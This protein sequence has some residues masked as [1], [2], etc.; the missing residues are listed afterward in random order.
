M[1][2]QLPETIKK[3]RACI[4]VESKD[5]QSFKWAV[6]SALHPFRNPQR[7]H[8]YKKFEQELNFSG[9]PFPVDP[10]QVPRF[11]EQNNISIDIYTFQDGKITLF[12]KTMS[13]MSKHVD[14][15][16]I[17]TLD[18]LHYVRIKKL[19]C[20]LK[21]FKV[22]PKVGESENINENGAITLQDVKRL[23][24][25]REILE[26][27]QPK[28][29]CLQKDV[30]TQTETPRIKARSEN[31]CHKCGSKN[32]KYSSSVDDVGGEDYEN[33]TQ[34]ELENK[35]MNEIDYENW[36]DP[37]ELV[38]RLRVLIAETLNGSSTH[39]NEIQWIVN[40]LRENDYIY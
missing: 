17:K 37:N 30:S 9:I 25:P 23:D 26:Q 14:L 22:S 35:E 1:S 6:L 2:Q 16:L 18:S 24:V 40:E 12:Y 20:L 28:E 36:D 27:L 4:N 13:K 34:G 8:P 21:N 29:S 38:D 31:S 32:H 7:V 10:S 3:T 19:S 33:S 39:I 11:E 15:L 5:N